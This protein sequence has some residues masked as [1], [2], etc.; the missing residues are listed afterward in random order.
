VADADRVAVLGEQ[1]LPPLGLVQAV[2]V[3][4]AEVGRAVPDDEAAGRGGVGLDDVGGGAVLA[5]RVAELAGVQRGRRDDRAVGTV[6]DTMD[7][8]VAVRG[9][10]G[11]PGPPDVVDGDLVAGGPRGHDDPVAGPDVRRRAG[12]AVPGPRR[13]GLE[14]V[15]DLQAETLRRRDG[16]TRGDADQ[17]AVA[18]H[19]DPHRRAKGAVTENPDEVEVVEDRDVLVRPDTRAGERRRCRADA[20]ERGRGEGEGG[21]RHQGTPPTAT[22]RGRLH[23]MHFGLPLV[24]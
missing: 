3:A 22:G 6:G 17:R 7:D 1:R 2:T 9:E 12:P 24:G 18:D 21:A 16:G 20:Q 10:F 23:R 5:G 4:E 11:G 15:V 19:L 8:D 13:S 14:A